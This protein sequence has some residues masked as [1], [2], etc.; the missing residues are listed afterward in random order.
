MEAGLTPYEALEA[1]TK[2]AGM[3]VARMGR[4][5][6]FGTV[7]V[8]QIASLMLLAE[9]PLENVSHTRQR[10]GVI[11]HGQWFTQAELDQMV[12]A[13]VATYQPND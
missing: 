2:N 3:S 9:N 12:N 6:S 7:A 11:V 10:L 1:G 5:G 4:D 13:F 8:G